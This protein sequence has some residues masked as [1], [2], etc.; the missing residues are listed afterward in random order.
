M[1]VAGGQ[2]PPS[3]RTADQRD[4]AGA[5]DRQHQVGDHVADGFK[6]LADRTLVTV[7]MLPPPI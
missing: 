7:G 3:T 5:P 1:A 2:R 6:R 4:R